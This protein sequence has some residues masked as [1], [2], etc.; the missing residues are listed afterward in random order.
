MC[1]MYDTNWEGLVSFT[2]LEVKDSRMIVNIFYYLLVNTRDTERDCMGVVL[3]QR[4][5]S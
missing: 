4:G 5:V 2:V 1:A 3:S